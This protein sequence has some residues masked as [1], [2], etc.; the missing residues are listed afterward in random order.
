MDKTTVSTP[1]APGAI[2]PYSQA[3]VGAGI[4]A[5]SG[6]LPIDPATGKMGTS[7]VEQTEQSMKNVIAI[8][9]ASGSCKEKILKC[10]L[11]IRNMGDFEQINKVYA[12]FFENDPLVR[13]VVE[14]SRLP[15]DADIEIDALAIL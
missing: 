14:V 8:L 7:I 13:L 11:F 9:E 5:V 2:G 4:V 10:C 12:T 15:K 3:T 6:Q 1:L